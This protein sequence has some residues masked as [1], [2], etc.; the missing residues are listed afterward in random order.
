MFFT[1]GAGGDWRVTNCRREREGSRQKSTQ[2]ESV[3]EGRHRKRFVAHRGRRDSVRGAEEK[4]HFRRLR[5]SNKSRAPALFFFA[6]S[7]SVNELVVAA[8]NS[9]AWASRLTD[10]RSYLPG[11]LEGALNAC[12][13]WIRYLYDGNFHTFRSVN[14]CKC[15]FFYEGKKEKRGAIWG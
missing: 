11:T 14:I 10:N 8:K 15:L 1:K 12:L 4:S 3:T 9:S 5:N 6:F 2:V 7:L 13:L